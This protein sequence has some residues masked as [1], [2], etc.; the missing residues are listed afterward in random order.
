MNP[1]SEFEAKPLYNPPGMFWKYVAVL[2]P[3]AL[4]AGQVVGVRRPTQGTTRVL[5]A[6]AKPSVNVRVLDKPI[7]WLLHCAKI[8]GE[9]ALEVRS[10]E[11]RVG[12]ECRSRWSPY[13]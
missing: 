1:D 8:V 5:N 7:F 13:H 4:Y 10:E 3:S 2:V 9:E 6:V 12:K 11:R